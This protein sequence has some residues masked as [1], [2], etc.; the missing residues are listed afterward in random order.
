VVEAD[1]SFL[2]AELVFK[3]IERLNAS[4]DAIV[5]D[6]FLFMESGGVTGRLA[7]NEQRT[8]LDQRFLCTTN[9]P[10]CDVW[11]MGDLHGDILALEAALGYI[12]TISSTGYKVVFLGDLFDDDGYGVE[13]MLRIFEL[14]CKQPEHF[15]LLTGNHD[16]ALYF[17]EAQG[18]FASSVMPDDMSLTLNRL[19][20]VKLGQAISAL[21]RQTPRAL[22]FSDGLLAAHGGFPLSDRWGTINSAVDLETDA[23]LQDFVW[24][25]I[26]DRSKYK[27]PNRSSK[28]CQYGY[29]DFDGFCDRM[30]E[31][32]IPVK[33]MVRGHDHLENRF[34][35]YD[36]YVKN[37]VLTINTLSRKLPRESGRFERMACIARLVPDYVA[38][39][40]P[41]DDSG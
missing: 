25:R 33:R 19:S 28:G 13:L 7:F 8:A 22:L 3:T 41:F 18:T 9:E 11:F 14:I 40:P 27:I 31:I 35:S 39:S 10:G 30:A 36:R 26:H 17:D 29:Q 21:Y 4:A 20:L 32:G 15:C 37:P 5:D 34:A 2:S 24:T 6:A 23:N 12:A 38:G 16:E 1:C